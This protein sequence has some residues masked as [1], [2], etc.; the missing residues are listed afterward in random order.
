MFD[1]I[2]KVN[3]HQNP[4]TLHIGCEAP[5]RTLSP[6]TARRRRWAETVPPA[7]TF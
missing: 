5:A 1:F 7:T 6:F 2:H 3:Y 4:H